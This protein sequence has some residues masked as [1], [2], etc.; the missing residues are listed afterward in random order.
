VNLD[1]VA[2]SCAAVVGGVCYGSSCVSVV[3]LER[4]LSGGPGRHYSRKEPSPVWCEDDDDA[5]WS[6]TAS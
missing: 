5:A 1:E 4:S 3:L 6:G 2:S